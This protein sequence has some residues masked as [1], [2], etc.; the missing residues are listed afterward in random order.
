[1]GGRVGSREEVCPKR[2]FKMNEESRAPLE[3][4]WIPAKGHQQG[5][6]SRG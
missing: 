3:Q 2:S 5:F 6:C 1:M 4:K